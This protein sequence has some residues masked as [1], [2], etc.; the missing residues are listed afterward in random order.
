MWISELFHSIQGEGSLAG[1]E[2]VFV[3][4]SG[5]N[6]R[7]WFCDT[8]Y[9]S[10]N[11]EGEHRS[12]NEVV[13]WIHSEE[14]EHVV[15]TGGEPLL[16]KELIPLTEHL[17]QEKHHITIETAGTVLLPVKANLMSISPKLANSTPE[18]EWRRRHD[19]RREQIEVTNELMNQYDYQ[20]KFVLDVPEDIQLVEAFLSKLETVSEEHVWLMPQA[21]SVEEIREKEQW[22]Q[23]SATSRGFQISPRIAH[24]TMG[25]CP[26]QVVLCLFLL[27]LFRKWSKYPVCRNDHNG[28]C[29]LKTYATKHAIQIPRY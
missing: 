12:W 3:R 5:C 13:Q 25:K 16:Q 7:C 27:C 4:T 1:V 2:S 19:E 15:I 29:N 6:L 11:A 24:R 23:E 8:P 10:W 18:G 20:L 28:N 17:K 26:R 14:C 21:R 22:L 9:T